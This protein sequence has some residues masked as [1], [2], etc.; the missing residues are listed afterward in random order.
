M[1]KTEIIES[2]VLERYILGTTT[3]EENAF[4]QKACKTFPELQEE[5]DNIEKALLIY[6]EAQSPLKTVTKEKIKKIILTDIT[7][8]IEE[9]EAKTITLHPFYSRISAAAGILLLFISFTYI[10]IVKNELRKTQGELAVLKQN[11]SEK[12]ETLARQLAMLDSLNKKINLLSNPGAKKI[13]LNGMNS[14]AGKTA[15]VHFNPETEEVYFEISEIT[16]LTENQQ[17]QLW[18]I[19]DGK[20]VSMGVINKNQKNVFQ[21]MAPIQKAQAFAVT[22][23]KTGGSEKPSLETMCLLGNI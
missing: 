13:V 15:L 5:L 4:V 20:P 17:Y 19:A 18:A 11:H 6:A 14:L 9:K 16:P 1:N 2:G 22:I 12:T 23:E 21:K 8:D 3:P 7:P 10:L